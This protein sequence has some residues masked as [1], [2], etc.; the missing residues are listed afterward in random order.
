MILG[1]KILPQG[2]KLFFFFF[3]NKFFHCPRF[4]FFLH[5]LLQQDALEEGCRHKVFQERP[6]DG[7]T[8]A[9]GTPRMSGGGEDAGTR[10]SGNVQWRCNG[11]E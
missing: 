6:L 4:S 10:Y 1:F 11:A 2:Q 3:S 7:R 9:Q 8:P 5:I